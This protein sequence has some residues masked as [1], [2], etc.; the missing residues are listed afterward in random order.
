M[1]TNPSQL[2]PNDLRKR[3]VRWNLKQ[4]AKGGTIL[5]CSLFLWLLTIHGLVVLVSAL[6]TLPIPGSDSQVLSGMLT[7]IVLVLIAW[8]GGSP[9]SPI[10]IW[11]KPDTDVVGVELP[12]GKLNNHWGVEFWVALVG[13]APAL[14]LGGI[15]MMRRCFSFEKSRIDIACRTHGYL[16]RQDDWVPYP[17]LFSQRRAVQLL[18]HLKLIYVSKRFGNLEIRISPVR[19]PHGGP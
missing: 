7:V 2:T 6:Q 13:I 9:R 1:P 11:D 4:C 16:A 3:I 15:Y 18:Y 12:E 14:T 8:I 10:F 17:K 19:L 5:G